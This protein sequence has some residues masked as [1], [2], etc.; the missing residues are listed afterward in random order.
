VYCRNIRTRSWS[1]AAGLEPWST[2]RVAI[3]VIGRVLVIGSIM[4]AAAVSPVLCL[5]LA[6]SGSPSSHHTRIGPC[7]W[8]QRKSLSKARSTMAHFISCNQLQPSWLCHSCSCSPVD[9]KQH[10]SDDMLACGYLCNAAWMICH[11]LCVRQRGHW[12]KQMKRSMG[13]C[14]LFC[15]QDVWQNVQPLPNMV[16]SSHFHAVDLGCQVSYLLHLLG[17]ITPWC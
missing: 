10:C 5:E 4:G 1:K 6:T 13:R 15:L 12:V 14:F 11:N 7:W 8:D 2:S 9:R 17:L 16:P 3:M